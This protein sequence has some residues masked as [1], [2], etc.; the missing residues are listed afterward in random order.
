MC[1]AIRNGIVTSVSC[2]ANF[3]TIAELPELVREFPKLSM[4]VHLNLN[5]GKPVLP[6]EEVPTLVDSEGRFLGR[7]LVRQLRLGRVRKSEI[8][9]KLDAQIRRMIELGVRPS[10]W[11]GHQD[12]HLLPRYLGVAMKVAQRHGML[13]MRSHRRFVVG[14]DGPAGWPRMAIHYLGHPRRLGR[15]AWCR[16][17]N[18]VARARG[19]KTADHQISTGYLDDSGNHRLET[20]ISLLRHLPEGLSGTVWHPAYP[21]D[22]LRAHATY[23]DQRRQELA[24]L[25]SAE[26]RTA[27]EENHVELV[28]Y[29][30][31]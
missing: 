5:V 6:P 10:H 2:N 25:T 20:W 11:D 17:A 16:A 14:D 21:D 31:L 24:V 28:S 8:E 3:P 22:T 12:M 29:F 9:R 7:R 30:D 19:F 26:V 27:V 1:E 4:G 23:V 15:H 13:R 18:A